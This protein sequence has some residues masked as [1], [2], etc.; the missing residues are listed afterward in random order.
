MVTRESLGGLVMVAWVVASALALGLT[1]CSDDL[2]GNCTPDNCGEE[3]AESCVAEP[4]FQCSTRTC[5]KY[6]GSEPFCTQ[7][8]TSD[9]ECPGGACKR[10]VLGQ[11][12]KY[13]VPSDET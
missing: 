12:T 4:N 5:G 6:E 8:C 1:G 11:Q 2:Y 7:E 9:G 10:F 13:C 3:T